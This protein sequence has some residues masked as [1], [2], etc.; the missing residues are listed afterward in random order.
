MFI[1]LLFLNF[2]FAQ[3]VPFIRDEPKEMKTMSH[4]DFEYLKKL[5]VQ[6]RMAAHLDCQL[7]VKEARGLK[8][9]RDGEKWVD[10]LEISY[11]PGLYYS[12]YKMN[13]KLPESAT[14]GTKVR[15]NEWSGIGEQVKVELG[16]YYQHWILLE[17]DGEGRIIGLQMGDRLRTMPCQL[18]R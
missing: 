13:F 12:G 9:F 10:H 14:I 15:N 5:L 8:K 18:K 6:P 7:K 3:E 4:D 11:D 1:L 17:H 2:A 16:D